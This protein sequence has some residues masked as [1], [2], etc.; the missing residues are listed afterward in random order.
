M[1]WRDAG[2]AEVAL[3]RACLDAVTSL[4]AGVAL[5]PAASAVELVPAAGYRGSLDVQVFLDGAAA[6]NFPVVARYHR[7]TLP[8]RVELTTDA[9]G[10]VAVPLDFSR[11]PSSQTRRSTEAS[12]RSA[13]MRSCS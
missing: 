4:L 12:T 10:V 13:C 2:G 8:R 11:W 5:K 1:V 6:P 7:G 9:N 3:D